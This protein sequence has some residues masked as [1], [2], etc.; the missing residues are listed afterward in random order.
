MKI[1]VVPAQVTTVEDRITGNLSVAQVA[2][3]A[4]P[5]F[6]G[7]LLFAV[8]PPNMEASP[9]KLILISGLALSAGI[10]AIRFKD[11]IILLWIAIL[12][13]YLLRPRLYVFNKNTAAYREHYY[14]PFIET[15]PS[16]SPAATSSTSLPALS[17]AEAAQLYV[18]LN[19][20]M[21]RLRFETTKEGV[22]HVHLTEVQ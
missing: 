15:A 7:S 19:D 6:G 3:C 5:V 4:I 20:P 14:E 12:L 16:A 2:L 18:R 11:K 13:R 22:L 21:G 1:T 10:A 8:L 9:Y 17:A